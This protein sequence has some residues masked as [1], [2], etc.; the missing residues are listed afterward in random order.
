[1]ALNFSANK[2]GK[3]K[4]ELAIIAVVLDA[5]HAKQDS[6]NVRGHGW[7]SPFFKIIE[8]LN[9]TEVTP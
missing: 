1:L 8:R 2:L 4:D 5:R 9:V 6:T 7:I 3:I